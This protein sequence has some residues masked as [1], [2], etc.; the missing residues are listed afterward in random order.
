[1]SMS[2]AYKLTTTPTFERAVRSLD[3]TVAER[4][5]RKL[6]WLATHPELLSEPLRNLPPSLTG[7]FKYRIGDYRVL[8]WVDHAQQLITLYTVK[9]RSTV[10]KDL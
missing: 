4:I 3:G 9:H 2:D 8:F 5:N 6:K 10:Y 7:L 1:M